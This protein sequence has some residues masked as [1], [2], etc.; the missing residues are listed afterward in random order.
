MS[1]GIDPA[2]ASMATHLAEL[3][4]P[5]MTASIYTKVET[6]TKGRA[7]EQTVNELKQVITDLVKDRNDLVAIAQSF[8]QELIG[9]R[10]QD[11]DIK[12]IIDSVIPVLRDLVDKMP[13]TEAS[14]AQAEETLDIL[15]RLLSVEMLTVLQLIGFNYKRAIGEPLT[16]LIQRLIGSQ[17]RED[18]Q[19]ATEGRRVGM[20]LDLAMLQIAQDEEAAE[21]LKQLLAIWR[22]PGTNN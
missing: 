8:E 1:M 21:R 3:A 2:L 7:N 10:L 16:L 15:T 14:K 18:Q 11:K 12:Y 13:T 19:S 22:N 17:M 6:I 5:S 20:E 4:I 9:Q